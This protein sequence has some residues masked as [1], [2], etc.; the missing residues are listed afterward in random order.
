MLSLKYIRFQ[1]NYILNL[2]ACIV[3]LVREYPKY[4]FQSSNED[5]IFVFF[6]NTIKNRILYAITA[7]L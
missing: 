6:M 2:Y 4:R 5:F 3:Y 1:H 7:V